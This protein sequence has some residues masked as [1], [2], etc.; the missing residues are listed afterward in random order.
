MLFIGRCVVKRDWQVYQ[1]LVG[2]TGDMVTGG[3][4]D[5]IGSSG[6][7]VVVGP[8]PAADFP[9]TVGD[10]TTQADTLIL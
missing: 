3:H 2:H 9:T 6:A 5:S 1:D 10:S 8:G 7:G 4:G